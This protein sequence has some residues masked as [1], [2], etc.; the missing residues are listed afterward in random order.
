[1]LISVK[2]LYIHIFIIDYF[3]N[4]VWSP[5][6]LGNQLN[7]A[8]DNS[9]RTCKPKVYSFDSISV[10]Y[11]SYCMVPT[12]DQFII[13][14]KSESISPLGVTNSL[15]PHILQL[16]R[17][18]CLWN[19]PGKNTRV[20]SHSLFQGIFP[21]QGSNLGLWHCRQNLYHGATRETLKLM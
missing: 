5:S 17:L 8:Q 7:T 20:N 12:Q 3:G 13:I 21:I 15:G 18:L 9:Q 14:M 4:N 1:M 11:I 2:S 6:T 19:S 16:T 10:Q